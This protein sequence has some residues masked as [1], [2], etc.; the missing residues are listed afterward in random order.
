M[1]S[2]EADA[3]PA[4]D[5]AD[6]TTK[7]LNADLDSVTQSTDTQDAELHVSLSQYVTLY[8]LVDHI[9]GGNNF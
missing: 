6:A 7:N 8:V 4:L 1:I 2:A 9:L 5:S 3:L